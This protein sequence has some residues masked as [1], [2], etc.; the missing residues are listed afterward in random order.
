M[1]KTAKSRFKS[2]ALSL[3]DLGKEAPKV[4]SLAF[5]THKVG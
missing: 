1:V 2:D 3:C 5:P 4:L